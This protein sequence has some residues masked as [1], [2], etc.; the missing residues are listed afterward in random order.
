[1]LHT[2]TTSA[3]PTEKRHITQ[4]NERNDWQKIH[5]FTF[6]DYNHHQRTNWLILSTGKQNKYECFTG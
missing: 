6:L 1:M 3:V 2:I 4:A 5:L